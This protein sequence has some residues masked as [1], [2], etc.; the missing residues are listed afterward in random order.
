[1][2]NSF[3]EKHLFS[4]LNQYGALEGRF[5]LDR[6]A[7]SYF[8]ANKAIGSKDRKW[9]ADHLYDLMRWQALLD[10]CLTGP[11]SWE[12][13]YAVYS[14]GEWK[15]GIEDRSLPAHIRISF[16]KSYFLFLSESLGEEQAIA[17]C[18]ASNE[19]APTTVRVNALKT[20]RDQMLARW[21]S[22][23]H[24]SPCQHSP[25]GIVFH[26]KE[27]FFSFPE[28][29]EG[30]FEIQDEGSQLVA[31]LVQPAPGDLVMDFCAGSGGKSL[32]FAHKMER[33]GQIFLHD[34]RL[35]ALQEGKKRLHRAGIQNA[36]LLP[37][38]SRQKKTL[39]GKMNW[40]LADVPCSG[41]G[42]LRRNPDMKWKFSLPS[43]EKLFEEQREIF[44]DALTY[45]APGGT[46]V[47]ATCSVFPQENQQQ[48][49]FFT[50]NYP[51]LC[52]KQFQSSPKNGEM[53]GF[54]AAELLLKG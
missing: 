43:L 32:A 19:P 38:D 20:T 3:R 14:E 41:S 16:P 24:V 52:Q 48:I 12:K 9:I 49:D 54:F 40:V 7:S 21:S 51:L 6:F 27:N 33:K 4:L 15:K 25:Q 42:T 2:K 1:M 47:Y 8:R 45:L 26:K 46:I 44:A 39:K 34:K 50:K 30:F 53:D 23:Y 10:H 28:F 37:Y 17:F 36:Q 29:K 5:P 13:R 31:D 35:S 22:L 18:R 11:A